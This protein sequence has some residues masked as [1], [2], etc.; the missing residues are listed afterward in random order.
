MKKEHSSTRYV[1]MNRDAVSSIIAQ[2]LIIL[3]ALVAIGILWVFVGPFIR[4][5]LQSQAGTEVCYTLRVEPLSCAYA[6]YIPAG[7]GI[8]G[9]TRPLVVLLSRAAGKGTYGSLEFILADSTGATRRTNASITLD[10]LEQQRAII[11]VPTDLS[12]IPVTLTTAVRLPSGTLCAP[13]TSYSCV[14]YN[15]PP[16]CA[17]FNCDTIVDAGDVFSFLDLYVLQESTR[18][19]YESTCPRSCADIDGDGIVRADDFFEYINA[20]SEQPPHPCP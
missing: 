3:M 10:E 2:I 18:C 9:E 19:E 17:D 12:F 7:L 13:T 14:P 15:A 1:S 5:G 8:Y 4:E 11:Y 20:F 6:N 16:R